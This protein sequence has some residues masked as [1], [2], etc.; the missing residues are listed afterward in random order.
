MLTE[1][2]AHAAV[3]PLEGKNATGVRGAEGS[4]AVL[5]PAPGGAPLF[6]V[7]PG[8]GL[9][10]AIG[11]PPAIGASLTPGVSPAI[12][13]SPVIGVSL[14]PLAGLLDVPGEAPLLSSAPSGELGGVELLELPTVPFALV[15]GALVRGSVFSC[16]RSIDIEQATAC[17]REL[18]ANAHP[19][20]VN[21]RM[22]RVYLQNRGGCR[23]GLRSWDES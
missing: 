11:V 12:G 16:G 18:A 9:P 14:L 22:A 7:P 3:L 1:A 21:V 10:P 5:P 8:S 15:V 6:G 13:V 4:M 2:S 20:L 17:N 19:G 23:R